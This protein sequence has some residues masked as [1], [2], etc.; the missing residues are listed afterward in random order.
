MPIAS[1][2]LDSRPTHVSCAQHRVRLLREKKAKIESEG[3]LPP[4][5]DRETRVVLPRPPLSEAAA[6]GGSGGDGEE[7]EEGDSSDDFE[8]VTPE[9][10]RAIIMK[11]RE[12]RAAR[13]ALSQRFS[14]KAE[15]EADELARL[16]VY[17][18]ILVS[19]RAPDGSRVEGLFH[20]SEDLGEIY[21]WLREFLSPECLAMP[22]LRLLFAA[23]KR[24]VLEFGVSLG[25]AGLVAPASLVHL[26]LDPTSK[27]AREEEARERGL[28]LASGGFPEGLKFLNER[29][30]EMG[31]EDP[32]PPARTPKGKPLG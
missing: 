20:P 3:P 6:A 22:G 2:T 31:R 17:P 8:M 13:R 5:L 10:E 24:E 16:L 21:A 14:S 32:Q 25:E 4:E 30:L 1:L 27:S 15:R 18:H 29:A 23:P 7:E 9:G 19:V 26:G 12:D 28:K 11:V